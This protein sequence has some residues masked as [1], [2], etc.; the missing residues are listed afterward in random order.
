MIEPLMEFLP[1]AGRERG[2]RTLRWAKRFTTFASLPEEQAFLRSYAFHGRA[3][4]AS[5]LN[6]DFSREVERVFNHH[7]EI[8]AQGPLDDQ[9][10]RMCQSDV[11]LFLAGLNLAYTDRASMAAST[12]VR[13]PF[14]DVEVVRAAFRIAGSEKIRGSN[15]KFALK[16]AAEAWLPKSI[17]YRPKGLFSAPLR[18][19]V[20]NDLK[21][22]VD[23]IL[24]DGELVRR[25]YVK[26]SYIRSLIDDD[27]AGRE[28]N[29]KEIWHLLTLDYWLRNQKTVGTRP[30]LSTSIPAKLESVVGHS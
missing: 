9:V 6:S 30:T 7:A 15:G 24:P 8:Y 20:R 16:K 28:D 25:D 23:D 17:V 19:W 27:R 10:N 5:V 13:V 3:D 12:E 29:C 11:R 14:V 18:A 2:Y 22:M 4:L 26:S 1:A 21:E